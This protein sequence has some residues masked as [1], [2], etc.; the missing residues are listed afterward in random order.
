[1]SK[2]R[3][4]GKP[5]F[6]QNSYTRP[7]L[8]SLTNNCKNLLYYS[9]IPVLRSGH[10]YIESKNKHILKSIKLLLF[11]TTN[12]PHRQRHNCVT[13]MFYYRVINISFKNCNAPLSEIFFH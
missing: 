10:S 11:L 8:N 4:K 13:N 1:M 12:N 2:N 5:N 6:A 7:Q 9:F 3:K